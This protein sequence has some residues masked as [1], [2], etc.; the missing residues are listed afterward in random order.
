MGNGAA[1]SAP[2]V[3]SS[4]DKPLLRALLHR[5]V[6]DSVIVEEVYRGLIVECATHYM[7]Y[8]VITLVVLVGFI[9]NQA[10]SIRIE[11]F[12]HLSV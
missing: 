7:N 5:I 4:A 3:A 1:H 12:S 6:G 9:L 2:L 8:F 11:S 10:R